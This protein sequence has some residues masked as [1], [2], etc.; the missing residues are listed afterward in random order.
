MN[1]PSMMPAPEVKGFAI[2]GGGAGASTSGASSITEDACY[3]VELKSL[4][5]KDGY[6]L[7]TRFV[8]SGLRVVDNFFERL[9]KMIEIRTKAFTELQMRFRT[10]FGFVAYMPFNRIQNLAMSEIEALIQNDCK[11]VN[12]FQEKLLQFYSLVD[13]QIGKLVEDLTPQSSMLVS[14]HGQSQRRY[15]VNVNDWLARNGFQV[16]LPKSASGFRRTVKFIAGIL[17]QDLK[18]YLGRTAPGLKEATLNSFNADWS[19]TRAFGLRYVPGIYINDQLRFGGPV[20]FEK[21]Y[22]STV[23][24]IVER[25]NENESTRKNDLSARPYR[26]QYSESKYESLLP[27]IWIDHPD[28]YFF[29]QSGAF[30]QSNNNYGP[31]N[32]LKRIEQDMFTGIK[33]RYPL[34]CISPDL[35]RLVKA[36]DE[37]DLTLAYKLIIRGMED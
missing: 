5:E 24:E 29:E 19:K 27:D 3:P 9:I 30:I 21:D 15:S 1:V 17:P 32:S 2:S 4:L 14:D 22:K 11:P 28:K 36:D 25:F 23:Q 37:R 34:L 16:K 13:E 7:D 10:N 6:I 26:P 8:S 33:G 31:I 18:K 12:Y 35:A 20:Q